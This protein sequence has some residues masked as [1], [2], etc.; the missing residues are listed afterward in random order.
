LAINSEKS[1]TQTDEQGRYVGTYKTHKS[2]LK[3]RQKYEKKIS[4]DPEALQRRRSRQYRAYGLN[5]FNTDYVT[6]EEIQEY[7]GYIR[8]IANQRIYA[9]ENGTFKGKNETYP[10]RRAKRFPLLD[11]NSDAEKK[12]RRRRSQLRSSAFAYLKYSPMTIKE[13][14]DYVSEIQD[15]ASHK[16]KTLSKD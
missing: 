12:A 6:E 16:L 2:Y 9:M 13:I 4:S 14:Q 10:E 5:F 11:N 15:A 8:L 1:L 7:T 3:A